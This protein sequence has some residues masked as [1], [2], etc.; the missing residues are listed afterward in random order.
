[1]D[2][3]IKEHLEALLQE[4]SSSRRL[5]RRIISLAGFLSPADPPDHLRRQ[6]AYLSRLLVRQDT[7]EAMLEP[8]MALVRSGQNTGNE[9]RATY[10]LLQSLE[11]ARKEIGSDDDINYSE[12]ITWLVGIAQA[13]KLI[14]I[15]GA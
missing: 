3:V 13:R 4:T 14:R 2:Q 12:L 5:G 10:A 6:L 11:Q 1:M 8:V 15:K 7:F 9:S